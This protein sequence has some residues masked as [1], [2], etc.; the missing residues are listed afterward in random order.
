MC[1]FCFFVDAIRSRR[2][3]PSDATLV[4]LPSENEEGESEADA[5]MTSGS[6]E[7]D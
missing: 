4:S 2:S 7:D 5:E 3:K 1:L 6:E